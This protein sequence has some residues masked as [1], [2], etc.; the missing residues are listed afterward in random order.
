MP[1]RMVPGAGYPK[2]EAAGAVLT[3]RLRAS[4]GASRA[5]LFSDD[6]D[7]VVASARELSRQFPA[8]LHAAGLNDRIHL[9]KNGVELTKLG[10]FKLPFRARKYAHEGK[11]STAAQ[12]AHF[13]LGEI[14]SGTEDLLSC[15]LLGQ[16]Y[17]T[18]HNLQAFDTCVHLD[19]DT[20]CS[21]D[22]KQRTARVWRQGQDNP[23]HE[24]TL[25]A[26]YED[27]NCGLDGT[28][29]EVRRY[30]QILEGDLFD[31]A[32]KSAQT[33]ELGAEWFEMTARNT[34]FLR[35]DRDTLNLMVSPRLERARP[36]GEQDVED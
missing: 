9:F 31:A 8:K 6:R 23:V 21:E 35:L 5:I 1:Q 11:D 30:H 28:L 7:M 14:L 24:Y 15:T 36:R 12:W 10:P 33:I 18:G 4:D 27:P 20:W 17:Q 2:I 16:S 3:E 25:D 32:I 29:D 19:R 26:V 34:Q 22:M 13:V